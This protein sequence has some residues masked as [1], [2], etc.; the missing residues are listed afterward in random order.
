MLKALW[1]VLSAIVMKLMD[2]WQAIPEDLRKQAVNAAANELKDYLG[3]R[4][5]EAQVRE[6]Q[7]Q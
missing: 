7:A 4:Y 3:K 5:D 2:L 1:T 6:G